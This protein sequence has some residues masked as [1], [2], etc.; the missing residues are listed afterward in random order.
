MMM[1][2]TVGLCPL[3]LLLPFRGAGKT[4]VPL[5]VLRER[6]GVGWKAGHALGSVYVCVYRDRCGGRERERGETEESVS[7]GL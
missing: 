1:K 4:H 7:Q 2:A 5:V 3:V 6:A